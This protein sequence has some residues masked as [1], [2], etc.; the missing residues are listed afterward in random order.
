MLNISWI[1]HKGTA[2]AI[3]T[4]FVRK[5][6]ILLQNLIFFHTSPKK[7]LCCNRQFHTVT[8]QLPAVLIFLKR[9]PVWSRVRERTEDY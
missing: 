5:I 7:E 4:N 9:C 6:E 2:L 3:V 1:R 8:Q